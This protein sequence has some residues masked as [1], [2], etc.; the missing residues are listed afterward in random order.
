MLCAC[1][2]T[3]S[4]I[5]FLTCMIFWNGKLCCINP[6]SILG[7]WA[8]QS[9]CVDFAA[10]TILLERTACS[11]CICM[12][13][14]WTWK[15][16]R[17][18]A[19]TSTLQNLSQEVPLSAGSLLWCGQYFVSYQP[20]DFPQI[21]HTGLFP[22]VVSVKGIL[23]HNLWQNSREGILTFPYIPAAFFLQVFPIFLPFLEV[24]WGPHLLFGLTVEKGKL[25][26]ASKG[27]TSSLLWVY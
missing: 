5:S 3:E 2:L 13:C 15:K 21:C 23:E 27:R 9:V 24:F 12:K 22:L 11:E 20:H 10:Y 1:F 19:N 17:W 7:V 14:A 16:L 25:H 8:S 6:S 18:S 26:S 4:P